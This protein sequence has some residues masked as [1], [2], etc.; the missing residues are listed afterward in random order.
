M[1]HLDNKARCFH[2]FLVS[3]EGLHERFLIVNFQGGS[4]K[5]F[6]DKHSEERNFNDS[7]S[8]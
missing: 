1:E 5:T 2:I 3:G 7:S 4:C 6:I 8:L